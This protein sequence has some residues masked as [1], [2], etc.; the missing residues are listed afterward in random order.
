MYVSQFSFDAAKKLVADWYEF[1]LHL[2][3]KY[4]DGGVKTANYKVNE[5]RFPGYGKHWYKRI[6]DQTGIII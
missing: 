1:F 2:L 5:I 4:I 6:V 3:G